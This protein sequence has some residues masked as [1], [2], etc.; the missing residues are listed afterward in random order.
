MLTVKIEKIDI[1]DVVV[2][3]GNLGI[4]P[5]ATKKENIQSILTLPESVDLSNKQKEKY[6]HIQASAKA[7]KDA[8]AALKQK[9]MKLYERF[10]QLYKD[11]LGAANV[12]NCE[13]IEIKKLVNVKAKNVLRNS[14]VYFEPSKNEVLKTFS[15][16]S[17]L[18][19]SHLGKGKFQQLLIDGTYIDDFRAGSF[20][21]KS[22]ELWVEVN[23]ITDLGTAPPVDSIEKS[24]LTIQ[25]KEEIRLQNLST[26]NKSS[27]Y[28]EK[29]LL[30]IRATLD[31]KMSLELDGS[32]PTNALNTSKGTYQTELEKLKLIYDIN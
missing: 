3:F 12:C 19:D 26:K 20:W 32:T 1:Y 21:S 30:L 22:D 8:V 11:S 29:K 28:E 6:K 2:G 25:E 13:L 31:Q 24:D 14:P 23:K 4:D 15:E 18:I 27:E 17:I 9:D 10:N 5:E 7:R 16:T